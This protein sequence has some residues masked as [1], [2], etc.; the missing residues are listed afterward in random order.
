[1]KTYEEMIQFAVDERDNRLRYHVWVG[2]ILLAEVYGKTQDE[3]GFDIG[4]EL[5]KRE[6]LRKEQ[7]K[8]EQRASNEAR[9]LANL[10]K[11]EQGLPKVAKEYTMGDWNRDLENIHGYR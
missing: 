5:A 9:R 3:V 8:A 6:Q 4:V 10:A 7:R 1:M 2:Y 11:K